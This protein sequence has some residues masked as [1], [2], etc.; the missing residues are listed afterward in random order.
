MWQAKINRTEVLM[1]SGRRCV[2]AKERSFAY[3][4]LYMYSLAKQIVVTG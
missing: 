3:G 2:E 4:L 1:E